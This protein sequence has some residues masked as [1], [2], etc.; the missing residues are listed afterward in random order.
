MHQ[1][2][3]V[4]QLYLNDLALRPASN[5]GSKVVVECDKKNS[6]FGLTNQ[7]KASSLFCIGSYSAKH[8]YLLIGVFSQCEEYQIPWPH[9]LYFIW[10]RAALGSTMFLSLL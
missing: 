6:I 1:S 10:K 8:I 5:K 3:L 2:I 4:G 9:T 7:V